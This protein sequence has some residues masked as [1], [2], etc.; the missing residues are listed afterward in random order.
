MEKIMLTCTEPTH[1]VPT[2]TIPTH[3]MPKIIIT[4]CNLDHILQNDKTL[5]NTNNHRCP[6]NPNQPDDYRKIIDGCNTKFWIDLFH[7]DNYATL[8]IDKC[9]LTWMKEAEKIG[10]LS[11]KFSH[12]FDDEIQIAIDKYKHGIENVKNKSNESEWFIRTERVSLKYGMHGAGPYNSMQQIIESMVSSIS[13]HQCFNEDDIA[14]KLYFMKWLKMDK[15]KEFRIF[16]YKNNVTA[17]S[18]QHLYNVNDWINNK[19]NG[20]I[21]TMICKI[22]KY[23]NDNIKDKMSFM[24]NY[25][26]DLTLIGDNEEPYFIEPNCFGAQYAAGSALFHWLN[27]DK[28]LH[29]KDVVEFRYVSE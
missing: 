16:I 13:G 15:E 12:M 22:I 24:E 17:I 26:M 14:C 7:K 3:T 5:Y 2:H 6:E 19:S 21:S 9:D 4:K 11:G 8:T 29:D 27:D 25:V 20:E 10:L 28:M 1:S 23:F 18:Q